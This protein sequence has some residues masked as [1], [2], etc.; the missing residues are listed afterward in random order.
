M[1]MT[2]NRNCY[3]IDKKN[4]IRK[5]RNQIYAP[6]LSATPITFNVSCIFGGLCMLNKQSF[7]RSPKPNQ[8]LGCLHQIEHEYNTFSF[9]ST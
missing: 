1:I 2:L 9:L 6:L 7:A 8:I 5:K 3:C 4:R